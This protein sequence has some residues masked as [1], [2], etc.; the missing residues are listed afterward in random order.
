MKL[1]FQSFGSGQPLVIIHGLFGSS[2]NWRAIAKQLA[3]YA[4]VIT[5]DLRNHGRSPQAAQQD[6]L[7]MVDDL[8]E[9]IDDLNLDKIDIMGHS[10]GGKVAMQ[11]A[12]TY[13]KRLNRL[14]VVDIAPRYYV[15]NKGHIAIFKTLLALDL[16]QYSKRSELDEALSAAIQDKAV[17]Q[18]LLMNIKADNGKLQWQINLQ[19]LYNNYASFGAGVMMKKSV[20]NR[21]CFIRGGRS[22]YIQKSDEVTI[23]DYFSNSEIVTIEPAGH[24]VHADAP[25]LFLKAVIDF[26]E[27]E[28]VN[29]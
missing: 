2:D 28:S 6:Y 8:V 12:M 24:W 4:H 27:Y 26:F 11:F 23:T 15:A 10:I 13:P 21:T 22:N 29:D 25:Q 18:F 7:L 14:V 1:H 20:T 19:A 17:R 9:L 3:N 16:A 5:V